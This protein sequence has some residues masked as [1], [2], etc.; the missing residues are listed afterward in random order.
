MYKVLSRREKINSF[1]QCLAKRYNDY[2][3]PALTLAQVVSVS[4]VLHLSCYGN[5]TKRLYKI[6]SDNWI[7]LLKKN[8]DV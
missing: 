6:Y 7:G 3:L 1:Y 2:V 5:R 8:G 4:C